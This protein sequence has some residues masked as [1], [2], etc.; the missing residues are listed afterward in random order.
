MGYCWIY[1]LKHL[2]DQW[3]MYMAAMAVAKL[4]MDGL[5]EPPTIP[6]TN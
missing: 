2:R 3:V 1:H 5:S 4:A 6:G